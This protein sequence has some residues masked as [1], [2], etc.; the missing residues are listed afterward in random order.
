[1]A[2]ADSIATL[3]A[4]VAAETTVNASVVTLLQTLSAEVAALK[5]NVTDP[6]TIAQIDALAATIDQQTKALADAV[7][8]NTPAAPPA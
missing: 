5:A 6:A 7:A 3:T 8:A 1:M 2:L 4:S